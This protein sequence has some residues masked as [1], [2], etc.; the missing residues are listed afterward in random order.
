MSRTVEP[1]FFNDGDR[2]SPD[3]SE[4]GP[5]FRMRDTGSDPEG[6]RFQDRGTDSAFLRP[7]CAASRET[8]GTPDDGNGDLAIRTTSGSLN[9]PYL[10]STDPKRRVDTA[11]MPP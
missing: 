4:G 9:R 7:F 11:F 8:T 2:R 3:D 6:P 1:V 10:G 5:T